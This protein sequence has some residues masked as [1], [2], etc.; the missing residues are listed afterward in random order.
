MNQVWTPIEEQF[1]R[2]NAS[3]ITDEVGALQ[4]SKIVS[5]TVTPNAW[6]K[7]RQQLGIKKAHGRGVCRLAE[8]A[9]QK[10]KAAAS[11]KDEQGSEV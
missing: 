8:S 3:K 7:K 1:I 5:R 11:A 9:V 4:L 2:D 10:N 6:R